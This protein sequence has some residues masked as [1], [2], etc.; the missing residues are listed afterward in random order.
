MENYLDV[1]LKSL[2]TI[3]DIILNTI[4]PYDIFCE[5]TGHELQVGGSKLI[6]SPLRADDKPTFGLFVHHI[7]D[8]LLFKDFAYETGDVFKFIKLYAL[9]H[10]NTRLLSYIDIAYYLN[11]KLSLD[12]ISG[13]KIN[14]EVKKSVSYSRQFNVNTARDIKFQSRQFTSL[15]K[16]YWEQYGIPPSVLKFYNVRSVRKLLTEDGRILREFNTDELCFVYV[17]YNKVKLY[18]PLEQGEF[19]WRNTCPAWY[20]Q[21]WE[22]RRGN[23]KLIITKSMKDLMTFFT[24]LGKDYDIIA[25]HTEGYNFSTK[26]TDVIKNSYTDVYVIYDFDRAGVNGANKLKR[27]HGWTPLFVDTKR[28]V[29][30]GKLKVIDKDISDF[31][32]NWGL[33]KTKLKCKQMNL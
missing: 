28:T 24:I 25:P 23:K 15:D 8:V 3:K 17:V 30:N 13:G 32:A 4:Q 18:Q 21:G 29:I 26:V 5:L 12:L 19:K 10:D 16:Q 20:I 7:D 22:Q 11:A 33:E 27:L 6:N 14:Y 2:P 1:Y 9:Y 31:S